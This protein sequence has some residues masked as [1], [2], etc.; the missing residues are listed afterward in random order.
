MFGIYVYECGLKFTGKIAPTRES[1]EKYL[2][3]KYGKVES[4]Y[5]GKLDA[6][7]HPI[8]VDTFVPWYNKDAFVIK[9]LEVVE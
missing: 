8:Y 3:N 4:V 1:A 5:T 6:N 2:G 9:E 7:G